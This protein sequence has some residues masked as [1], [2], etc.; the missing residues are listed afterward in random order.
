MVIYYKYLEKTYREG[1]QEDSNKQDH[2]YENNESNEEPFV[3]APYYEFHGLA[4]ICEPKEGRIWTA[5]WTLKHTV[6]LTLSNQTWYWMAKHW[7]SHT[8][9]DLVWGSCW[10]HLFLSQL[11]SLLPPSLPPLPVSSLLYP[12]T[13]KRTVFTIC[14]AHMQYASCILFLSVS[15]THSQDFFSIFLHGTRPPASHWLLG[16]EWR[17]CEVFPCLG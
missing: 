6:L 5:V 16:E 14:T 12:N 3:S 7:Y 8:L 10:V 13:T 17:R 4:W 11:A 9:E 1:I 2:Q 15:Y